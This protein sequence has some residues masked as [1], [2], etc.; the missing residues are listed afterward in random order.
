MA[1][2]IQNTEVYDLINQ[3]E[4]MDI[5]SEKMFPEKKI[6]ENIIEKL[7]LNIIPKDII[8]STMTIIC[9]SEVTFN[10]KNIGYFLELGKDTIFS[11]NNGS[12]IKSNRTLNN[13]KKKRNIKNKK[14]KKN[15]Y[16][17]VSIVVFSDEGKKIN[18]KLFSNGS[19]QMTGCKDIVNSISALKNLFIQLKKV[20]A[21]YDPI[22][23]KLVE[24]SFVENSEKLEINEISNFK[25]AMINSN[26]NIGFKVDRDKLYE[27]ITTKNIAECSYDPII[28][29]CVNIKYE[30]DNK[31]VSI[32]VFESGSII[33]T[34][35]NN[36]KHILD[37]YN[38]INKLLCN[39]YKQIYK[40]N[41]L[42][43]STI[44]MFL[45]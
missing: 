23:N 25:I 6:S 16:N 27:L 9:K 36:G 43:N 19:I 13:I 22:N 3:F 33:I 42:S 45:A 4:R 35:A 34:G 31:T 11:V 21:I 32:F 26:F 7:K 38:F 40:S 5:I 28:H 18:I 12:D 15:F 1:D 14:D 2:L 8:I 17:Q 29:A 30:C 44:M 24:K 37:A 39:N 10:V 41:I 20:K